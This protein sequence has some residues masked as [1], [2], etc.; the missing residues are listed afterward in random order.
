MGRR[1][2][3]NEH[4]SEILR[5]LN[6]GETSEQVTQWLKTQGVVTKPATVRKFAGRR[7][8]AQG[9]NGSD[10]AWPAPTKTVRAEVIPL[11]VAPAAS[12]ERIFEIAVTRVRDGQATMADAKVL[13]VA[14]R[15]AVADALM[16][17]AG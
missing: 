5:R 2:Q 12:V 1:S 6:S 9:T 8:K 14:L 7:R 11:E 13:E 4:T 16:K 10:W 15:A 17:G 3:L